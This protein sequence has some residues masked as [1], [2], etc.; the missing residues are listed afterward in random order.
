MYQI[1]DL[2]KTYL[3]NT[4]VP[5]SGFITQKI[6]ALGLKS[7]LHFLYILGVRDQHGTCIVGLYP[8]PRFT[9]SYLLKHPSSSVGLK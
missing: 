5:D 2:N 8:Y 3:I 6:P 9:D 4:A 7:S 1:S